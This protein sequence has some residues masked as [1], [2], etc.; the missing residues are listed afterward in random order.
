MW[1]CRLRWDLGFKNDIVLFYLIHPF[2]VSLSFNPEPHPWIVAGLKQVAGSA[3]EHLHVILSQQRGNTAN[4]Q[5]WKSRPPQRSPPGVV[6]ARHP[7]SHFQTD[8]AAGPVSE[9]SL[10]LG[11]VHLTL[12]P[13]P[14]L[15]LKWKT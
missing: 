14:L 10:V 8:C 7:L 9:A 3:G 4:A 5:T 11:E 1:W 12:I 13:I 15:H 6:A 2:S